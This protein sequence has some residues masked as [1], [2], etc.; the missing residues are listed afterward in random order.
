M[1]F[2]GLRMLLL[3]CAL[4]FLITLVQF[5]IVTVA[6]EK[7]GLSRDTAYLL[8][9][10]TLAGSLVNVPLFSIRTRP[11]DPELL[12]QAIPEYLLPRQM[13]RADRTVFEPEPS[14]ASWNARRSN[15]GPSACSASSATAT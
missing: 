10:G 11:A 1:P 15:F 4:A 12:Q 7:L 13:P 8:L 6:F 5:N 3:L 9:L 14:T 2:P